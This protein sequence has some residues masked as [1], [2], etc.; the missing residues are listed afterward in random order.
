MYNNT[1]YS[2]E[3]LGEPLFDDLEYFDRTNVD[4][5]CYNI[6]RLTNDVPRVKRSYREC[7]SDVDSMHS[8]GVGPLVLDDQLDDW[9]TMVKIAAA[10]AAAAALTPSQLNART[11]RRRAN[12]DRV[13]RREFLL[14]VDIK[15]PHFSHRNKMN[16]VNK[17]LQCAKLNSGCIQIT[18]P[19]Q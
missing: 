1:S 5:R 13:M 14:T 2:I 3:H 15:L 4:N 16:I 11:N 18:A 8:L 9:Q 19:R 12:Y 10:T 17:I 7:R 6:A